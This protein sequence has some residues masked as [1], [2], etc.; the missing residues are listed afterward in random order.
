MW[1]V[2]DGVGIG[3]RRPLY[4]AVLATD[5]RID[6]LEIVPENFMDLG[7]RPRD[8]L[9][10][11]AV[12]WPILSHGVSLSVGGPDP[13]SHVYLGSLRRLL[14]RFCIPAF[15]DHLCWSTA[16]G[17]HFHDLLPLPQHEDAVR[18]C[19][20]RARQAAEELSRALWLENIT[21]YAVMPGSTMGA[22]QFVAAVIEE[23]DAGLLLDVNN[24]F[25]NACNHGY[26]PV[27]ALE[28]LPLERTRQIHLAGHVREGVRLL[29][30][31]GAGVAPEVWQLLRQ[32][33]KRTG[34]V[35][36]L[37]EWDTDI[38]P[39]DRVL[40]EADRARAI[41]DEVAPCFGSNLP[42]AAE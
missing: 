34:R 31:H 5:R 42:V 36:I 38:P 1:S 24:V 35:P 22:E 37:L 17:I 2:P 21:Y 30:T 29:D 9:E 28:A 25:V 18:W 12:R 33:L 40:D 3:L 8:V 16:R 41:L 15:S 13:L 39:L 23:A 32:A 10:A 14:D 7:G 27:A 4:D 6:F 20:A 11:C 19:A 26:D